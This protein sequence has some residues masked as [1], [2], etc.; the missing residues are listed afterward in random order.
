M[1]PW[2]LFVVFLLLLSKQLL[3]LKKKNLSL[4]A[5]KQHPSV[6]DLLMESNIRNKR[7]R[8]SWRWRCQGHLLFAICLY[9]GRERQLL[10]RI[11]WGKLD[12]L[13]NDVFADYL[14]EPGDNLWISW[15]LRGLHW[16]KDRKD[17]VAW[18][19]VLKCNLLAGNSSP[20]FPYSYSE[21]MVFTLHRVLED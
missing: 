18:V 5:K 15:I 13:Y 12:L 3:A 21:I 8:E 20:W 14:C 19:L 11:F 10:F 9:C 16:G 2:I 7:R 6:L 4:S 17:W 1:L